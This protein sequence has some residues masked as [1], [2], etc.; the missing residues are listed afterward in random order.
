MQPSLAD[1]AD[2]DE[3]IAV[4]DVND[5]TVQSKARL[6]LGVVECSI[7]FWSPFSASCFGRSPRFLRSGLGFASL[8]CLLLLGLQA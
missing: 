6:P 3:P 4:A 5:R 2:V 8:G 7:K 1:I